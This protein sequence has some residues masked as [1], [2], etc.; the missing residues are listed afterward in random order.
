MTCTALVEFAHDGVHRGGSRSSIPLALCDY[1]QVQ[2]L[3]AALGAELLECGCRA[4]SGVN[5]VTGCSRVTRRCC[6]AFAGR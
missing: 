3:E 6:R 2:R 4:S 5:Y 1:P